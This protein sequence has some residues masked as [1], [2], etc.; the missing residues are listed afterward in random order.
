MIKILGIALAG[1]MFLSTFTAYAGDEWYL[2]YKKKNAYITKYKGL[3]DSE[4]EC[5]S[6]RYSLDSDEVYLGCK[7]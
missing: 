3:Y 5:T 1:I 2:T 6:D 7:K 4:I